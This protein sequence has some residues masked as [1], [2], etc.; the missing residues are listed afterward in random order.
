MNA[1]P[2]FT[3]EKP[4]TFRS[5]Q[6]EVPCLFQIKGAITAFLFFWYVLSQMFLASLSPE[7]FFGKLYIIFVY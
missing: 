4:F 3:I 5:M 6:I 2:N 1:G 7:L